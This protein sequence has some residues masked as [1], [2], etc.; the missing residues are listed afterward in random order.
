MSIFDDWDGEAWE[1]DGSSWTDDEVAD[2]IQDYDWS[3]IG[4]SFDTDWYFDTGTGSGFDSSMWGNNLGTTNQD[5]LNLSNPS[6]NYNYSGDGSGTW[7]NI[8]G[9]VTGVLKDLFTK[10]TTANT[11][12]QVGATL[13]YTN[14]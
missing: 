4:D 1:D 14:C 10:G 13:L 12:G 7:G 3:N 2:N 6:Y 8:G 11:V 5:T 9:S